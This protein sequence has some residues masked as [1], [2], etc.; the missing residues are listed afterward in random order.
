MNTRL[1]ETIPAIREELTAIRASGNTIGL[2]PTMGALHGGH[3]VLIEKALAECDWVVVSIFVNPL[4]FGP[5]EDLESYPRDLTS[6]LQFCEKLG[7][8]MVFA[9]TPEQMYPQKQRTFV[10]V[11]GVNE[12][13]CGPARPGHFRGVATVVLKL[14]N[15]VQPD[16]AYFGEKD[17]QQ[18]KMIER[19]TRDLNLPVA[20]VEVPTVREEDGL[21]MSSR[22]RYLTPEQRDAATVLYRALEEAKSKVDGGEL[23][24]QAVKDAA[25]EVLKSE[26]MVEVEYL[27]V[28][29]PEEMKPTDKIEG[30]VRVAA[31]IRIGSARLI[32]NMLCEG[33]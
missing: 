25:L 3:G 33:W 1:V 23:D 12:Y 26:P 19:M 2:V 10:E 6:D 24:V 16:R 27:E 13:L 9:P 11:E 4:Q 7:V 21:A 5:K 28:V 20:I 8:D 31:A 22:N 29:D 15:I 30:S 14:L 32:D 17:A 18:L